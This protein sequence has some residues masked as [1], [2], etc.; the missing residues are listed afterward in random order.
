MIIIFKQVIILF[1]FAVVGYTLCKSN[2]VRSEHS[3]ILSKLLVY[4]FLPCNI[5]KTY[6]SNFKPKY[7]ID[8]YKIIVFSIIILLCLSIIMHFAAKLFSKDA[9]DRK[10]YEYSLMI[11]NFGYMGYA[12]AEAFLGSKGLM[13]MMMFAIPVSCYVYVFG[14][15]NLT[16]RPLTLK[17]MVNPVIVSM[18][19]G[20]IIGLSNIQLPDFLYSFLVKSSSCMA[21]VS[22]LLAG[23]VVSGF[24]LRNMLKKKTIYILAF[25]RLIL[26]PILL[27]IISSRFFGIETMQ[28]AILLYAMPCGLNTIVFPKLVDENCEIGAGVAFITNILACVSIPLVFAVFNIVKL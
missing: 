7:V 23:I 12:L 4:V 3:Q 5:I 9:Y 26:I 24:S 22:M 19:L 11:P 25:V 17:N 27:G 1:L 10:V 2:I 18:V 15:S 13:N 21:P 8:N 20:M 28:S 14:F 16:K 6:S